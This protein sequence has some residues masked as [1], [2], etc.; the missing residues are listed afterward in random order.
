MKMVGSHPHNG[1]ALMT[2]GVPI[3]LLFLAAFDIAQDLGLAGYSLYGCVKC[4]LQSRIKVWLLFGA[5]PKAFV[6]TG[7]CNPGC[8]PDVCQEDPNR[9]PFSRVHSCKHAKLDPRSPQFAE[10][11]ILLHR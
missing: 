2:T 10:I 7:P 9:F 8:I 11:A 1:R 4:G 5:P 3:C 6:A